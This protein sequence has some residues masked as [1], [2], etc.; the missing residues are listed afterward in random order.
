MPSRSRRIRPEVP[1]VGHVE[2]EERFARFPSS[3]LMKGMF[4]S[5]MIDLGGERA[6]RE[7]EGRLV[8]RPQLG[9]YVPFADY[10]QVDFSRLAHQVAITKFPGVDVVE[11]MRRLARRDIETFAQSTAGSVMLALVGNDPV[12]ALLKLPDMYRASLKGGSVKARSTAKDVVELDY[13]DFYGWLDCYPIGHV[14][15]LV[16]HF[17]RRC[18]IE[19]EAGSEVAALLRVHLG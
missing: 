4:F 3:Y 2:A 6:Y 9:R 12:T 14:E 11:A 16:G 19:V 8:K 13:V 7:V 10:P 18:E 17:G 5:R 15:G 1:L